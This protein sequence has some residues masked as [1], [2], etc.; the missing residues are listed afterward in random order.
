MYDSI[1]IIKYIYIYIL[2]ILNI[3]YKSFIYLHFNII[4]YLFCFN[5]IICLL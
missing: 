1:S 5:I 4:I 3:L 2:F